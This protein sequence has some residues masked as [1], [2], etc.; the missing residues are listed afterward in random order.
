MKFL[1]SIRKKFL[2]LFLALLLTVSAVCAPL[3]A[4]ATAAEEKGPGN[5]D[6]TS[7][8]SDLEGANVNGK[9]FS[10]ED[11]PYD[12]NG[13][14]Q[15]ISLVEFCYSPYSYNLQDFGLYIYVY[16]PSGIAIGGSRNR[17]QL[18]FSATGNY[19]KY[20]LAL[21]DK[22]EGGEME[23]RF[24]KF[25]I[26]LSE[27]DRDIIFRTV[28]E[29]GRVYEISGI[30][31][32]IGGKV[33]E[34]PCLQR[35]TY[36]GYAE[37]Y[38]PIG[39][40]GE[41]L[42]CTADGITKYLNLKVTPTYFRPEGT[43]GKDCITQDSLSSVYFAVPKEVVE[44][45]GELT[46]IRGEYLKALTSPIFV[47]GNKDYYDEFFSVIG[48]DVGW[49]LPDSDDFEAMIVGAASHFLFGSTQVTGW[50]FNYPYQKEYG[51][52]TLEEMKERAQRLIDISVLSKLDYVLYASNG[53]ADTYDVS[54]EELRAYMEWYTKTFPTDEELI[55][56]KYHPALFEEVGEEYTTFDLKAGDLTQTLTGEKITQNWWQR[57]L[58]LTS[59]SP[60]TAYEGQEAIHVITDSDFI[61]NPSTKKLNE[62]LTSQNLYVA[63]P[64]VAQL[65][66]FYDDHKETDVVFLIRFAVDDYYSLE[67]EEAMFDGLGPHGT[68]PWL[69]FPYDEVED[70][71]DSYFPAT[72]LC[73]KRDS[74]CWIAQEYT[75]LNFDVI[76]VAF[77]K[78][79]VETVL[80]V[81]MTPLEI[82]ADV[83]H[84]PVT[85]KL[86]YGT[87]WW[88]WLV[89]AIIALILLSPI[90]P[91]IL[92]ILIWLVMAP[93]KL[94]AAIA[95]AIQAAAERSRRRR[96]EREE[97]KA[98]KEE[99]RQARKSREQSKKKT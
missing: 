88:V 10:V 39:G 90:L 94:I 66:R 46:R 79:G 70:V 42:T 61:V 51:D 15:V 17:I 3:R 97:K 83:T 93:F 23:S 53:D 67:A 80:P 11:Y 29:E 18:R 54:T 71:D 4:Y 73:K 14:P 38:G 85:T 49:L 45:Y 47:T 78:N 82:I 57:I 96:E 20:S 86:T 9:P 84:P 34:Y 92:K 7:V 37:G 91:F 19:G 43:N 48:T 74:N 13:I 32:S 60:S 59:T 40:K 95:R 72:V 28:A 22:T 16:N 52:L 41:P 12:K 62:A 65:K 35:Y 33:T 44:E 64:D 98:R 76:D 55:A 89:V 36:T 8:L 68:D 5:F 77:T 31:I 1:A 25:K 63:E 56:G 21:L 75:Y 69:S 50:W 27:W 81:I 58:G 24:C 6:N 99:A 87:P 30:E 26:R 2:W